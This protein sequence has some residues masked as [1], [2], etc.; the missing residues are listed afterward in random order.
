MLPHVGAYGLS[1]NEVTL[2]SSVALSG[3]PPELRPPKAIASIPI[4]KSEPRTAF[5][6]RPPI[7]RARART[8]RK[9]RPKRQLPIEK[10]VREVVYLPPDGPKP[11]EDEDEP[12]IS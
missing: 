8:C 4:A 9:I 11:L 1:F 12:V 10:I 7:T 5:A 2:E 6:V 3:C